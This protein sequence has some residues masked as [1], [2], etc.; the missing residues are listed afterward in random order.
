[1]SSLPAQLAREFE[2]RYS[3]S[4]RLFRAPGRVNL[5]GEHTDYNGGFVFPAAID[6]A[7][8]V[9]VAPREDRRLRA[10]SLSLPETLDV[11]LGH[12]QPAGNWTDFIT[13]VAALLQLEVGADL[14]I[15]TDVPI[16][17]GLSSSAALTV[18]TAFALGGGTLPRTEIARLCQ[19]AENEF[20][21]MQCGIMDPFA[22][23]LGED[24]CALRIDCRD[25]SYK[26]VPLPGEVRLVIANTM[27]KHE[28]AASAYNERRAACESAAARLGVP[29]LR[30]VDYSSL[31]GRELL[32]ARH[33]MTEN[34]RVIAFADALLA[35]DMTKAGTAMYA[36][37][38]S[39]KTDY[40]VSCQE[41]DTMVEIASK[42]PGVHGARMTGGG[43][44][45][46]TINLVAADHAP[47]IVEQLT[48][49][50]RAAT[51][52]PPHIFITRP[53]AG[54]SEIPA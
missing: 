14:L 21:G 36:S 37:H 7:T 6:R 3:R 1:M 11:P 54:A 25:L 9:A 5:I 39:L 51:G 43:F 49:G 4:A 30:D 22:S 50:Y 31:T 19:R 10:A 12:R 23:C 45:G 15:A 48:A 32:C 13:G 8:Y 34:S 29:F 47:E 35:G 41:L 53:S 44:G 18:S 20:T 42:L 16:G 46:C 33:V 24:G 27:V 17:G 40:E 28:L 52:I 26:A 2:R 38:E